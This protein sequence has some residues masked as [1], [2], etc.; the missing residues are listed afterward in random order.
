MLKLPEKIKIRKLGKTEHPPWD[1]LLQSCPSQEIV[2]GM[3][4]K[5]ACYVAILRENVVGVFVLAQSRKCVSEILQFATSG[6]SS[7]IAKILVVRAIEKA[8]AS[9]SD[10][11]EIGVGNSSFNKLE[12]FQK[13]GFRISRIIPDYYIQTFQKKIIES[14]ILCRDMLLL[15][16]DLH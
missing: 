12:L 1:L 15:S 2:Q 11:L 5:G 9:N 8:K 14:G 6:D 7:E 16:L 13:Y 4:A 10:I 3:L